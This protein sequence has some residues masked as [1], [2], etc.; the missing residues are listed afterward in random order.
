MLP[1][2]KTY[3]KNG[4]CKRCGKFILMQEKEIQ[5]VQYSSKDAEENNNYFFQRE[6]KVKIETG[7]F[8]ELM[9]KEL[10]LKSVSYIIDDGIGAMVAKLGM[11]FVMSI[12]TDTHQIGREYY[13]LKIDLKEIKIGKLGLIKIQV[14][15]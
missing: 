12:H 3:Y 11:A 5:Q 1:V 9:N 13:V 15:L 6:N 4:K 2:I 10:N 14:Y 7:K 8:V